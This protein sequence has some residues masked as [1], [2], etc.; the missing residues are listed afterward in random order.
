MIASI[1]TIFVTLGF[2]HSVR[3]SGWMVKTMELCYVCSRSHTDWLFVITLTDSSHSSHAP[4]PV[5]VP[6]L[7][8]ANMFVGP[9]AAMN[10]GPSYLS[11]FLRN[12][13]PVTL[14]NIVGGFGIVALTNFLAFSKS[15]KT[16]QQ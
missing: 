2:E 13:V 1:I 5:S 11:F 16:Q 3:S 12:L 9:F 14:G 4:H 15:K 10:G 8:V 6:L 7:Q